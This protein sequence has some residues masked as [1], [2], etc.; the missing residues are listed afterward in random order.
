MCSSKTHFYV[1]IFLSVFN[2]IYSQDYV[3]VVPFGVNDEYSTDERAFRDMFMVELDKSGF[4]VV[5]RDFAGVLNEAGFQRASGLIDENMIEDIGQA[6]GAKFVAY[7]QF[8]YIWG[9]YNISCSLIEVRTGILFGSVNVGF[10]E[11]YHIEFFGR[12]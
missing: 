2:S 8:Q 9:S 11:I 1:L 4:P 10:E 12:C 7:G 3:A 5:T 6:T